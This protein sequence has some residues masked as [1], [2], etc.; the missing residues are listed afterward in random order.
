MCHSLHFT[1]A[2]FKTDQR[3]TL[4]RN[5]EEQINLHYK[6][7][8]RVIFYFMYHIVMVTSE[9]CFADF[10]FKVHFVLK[11]D[12]KHNIPDYDFVHAFI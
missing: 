5:K 2:N 8:M 4:I 12:G 7:I 1:T 9:E 3:Q 11:Y 10:T 6:I